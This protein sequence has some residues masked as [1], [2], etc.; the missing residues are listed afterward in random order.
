MAEKKNLFEELSEEE[1]L[2]REQVLT[3]FRNVI[4]GMMVVVVA[5]LIYVVFIVNT[6]NPAGPILVLSIGFM[7]IANAIFIKQ[8]KGI[9]AELAKR[10]A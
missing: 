2:K 6:T 8:L 9:K 3:V 5:M 1:L 10:N 7:T 4:L